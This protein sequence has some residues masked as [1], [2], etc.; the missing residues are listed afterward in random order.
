[1]TTI[2]TITDKL[3]FG[4]LDLVPLDEIREVIAAAPDISDDLV[5]AIRSCNQ[6]MGDERALTVLRTSVLQHPAMPESAIDG[7]VRTVHD[8]R[9]LAR[10]PS[11]TLL[12]VAASGSSSS[13][14]PVLEILRLAVYV[15]SP[16]DFVDVLRGIA[17][18]AAWP[19]FDIREWPLIV[20][21]LEHAPVLAEIV[22]GRLEK[23]GIDVPMR[24][25]SVCM[26]APHL[27]PV[28]FVDPGDPVQRDLARAVL[29]PWG[30]GSDVMEAVFAVHDRV[31]NFWGP[32]DLG[33]RP[34]FA[35]VPWRHFEPFVPPELIPTV[36]RVAE[37]ADT[38]RDLA[39]L[40]FEW[41]ASGCWVTDH[42]TNALA[43][44]ID[45]S[46]VRHVI[47][48]EDCGYEGSTW[49]RGDS[50][51]GSRDFV[52]LIDFRH[53]DYVDC[54]E[55]AAR[56]ARMSRRRGDYEFSEDGGAPVVT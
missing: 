21:K 25:L 16:D 4:D 47:V 34:S 28:L 37:L 39:S 12:T 20:A 42:A 35:D 30:R 19:G 32:S 1:M 55:C 17:A 40:P 56:A 7:V 44:A 36:Q 24:W 31:V 3:L 18:G 26:L 14:V 11:L 13:R 53:P 27:V 8:L 46:V 23:D 43:D 22:R 15:R 52:P 6:R 5:K 45:T 54:P 33:R 50:L 51:C 48:R 41:C 9:Y 2:A 10:N 49:E 38:M 29:T